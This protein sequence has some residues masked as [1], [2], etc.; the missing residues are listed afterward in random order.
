[1]LDHVN[2]DLAKQISLP[3]PSDWTGLW[4]G[5]LEKS[6]PLLTTDSVKEGELYLHMMSVL[7]MATSC[8]PI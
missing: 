7:W 2:T 4:T 8:G 1:M 5:W 6:H 3:C